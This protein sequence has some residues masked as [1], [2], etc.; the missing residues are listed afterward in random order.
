LTTLLDDRRRVTL[1]EILLRVVLV[2]VVIAIAQPVFYMDIAVYFE[3]AQGI[4]LHYL[5]YRDFLWEYPPLSAFPLALIPATGGSRAAFAFAFTSVM[6]VLEYGS[7]EMLRRA[8]PEH[9]LQITKLWT[10]TVLPVSAIAWFRLDF[11]SVSLATLALIEMVRGRS[12]AFAT[13]AGFGAKLWPIAFGVAMA[14]QRRWRE[15]AYTVE[16]ACVVLLAWW[17]LSPHGFHE[18]LRYRR[19]SGFQVESMPGVLLLLAGR[20]AQWLYGAQVVDDTGWEWVQTLYNVI[21]VIVPLATLVIAWRRPFN[22]VALVGAVVCALLLSTRLL[23]PQFLVWLAPLVAWLWPQYRRQ[24]V[25]YGICTWM[26]AVVI[27]FYRDFLHHNQ[28]VEVLL[29]VRNVFLLLL[30][31]ELYRVAFQRDELGGARGS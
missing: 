15:L 7:L 19:G 11:I 21:V 6:L 1:A 3:R 9:R 25:L 17:A 2:L 4:G 27:E 24:G 31:I 22:P 18:F 14:A 29:L 26:T 30:M 20:R 5:P 16:G 23:S 10:L 12:Y 13:V 8:R 28:L